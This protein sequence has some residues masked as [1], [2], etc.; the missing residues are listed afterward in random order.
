RDLALAGNKLLSRIS[1][2][3]L[4]VLTRHLKA[5][6]LPLRKRLE[7]SGRPIDQ[8][9]FL[10]SGFASVVANGTPADRVEVGMI[11][12]EGKTGLAVVI[13]TDRSP[14]D[15]YMQNAGKGL[16]MP[17]AE[18]VKA[19]R[20]STTLRSSLLL[21]AH[22]FLVQATQTAKANGR[23]KIEERLARWLLMAHDRL[24]NDDLVITHEFLSVMLGVR[25]PGVTV[26]LSFLEKAGLIATD[27]GVISIIDRAG[28]KRA[29]TGAYGVAEAELTRVFG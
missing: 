16:S 28:L 27:R 2:R 13:G 9:Y 3:D 17:A 23:S 20:S 29:A 14:N 24:E 4:K 22:A 7:T 6:D 19:M 21:Y 12:R 25:R 10:E 26:A 8:V 11:G 1:T 5:I 18:L 15:T